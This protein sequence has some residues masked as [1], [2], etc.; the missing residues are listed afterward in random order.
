MTEPAPEKK[1]RIRLLRAS[2]VDTGKIG[3]IGEVV[4]VSLPN[5]RHL[6]RTG[7][8]AEIEGESLVLTYK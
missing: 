8:A 1:V 6:V 2:V 7:V 5:A 4:F 3:Q